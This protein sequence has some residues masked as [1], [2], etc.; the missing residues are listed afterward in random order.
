MVYRRHALPMFYVKVPTRTGW[1]SRSTGTADRATARQME[2][3]LVDLGPQ[4]KRTWDVIEAVLD[5]RLTLGELYDAW[6]LNDL[7]G[8][9]AR[10]ADEDL[11]A[12]IP[13]WRAWLTDRVKAATAERYVVHVRTLMPDGKP[14]LRSAFTG[15][16]V[17]RWLASRTKLV[18]KRK[19]GGKP[20]RKENPDA[21]LA[22]ASTKRRYFAAVQSF[23]AYLVEM[24]ILASNPIRD[25][26]PPPA[27]DP[28]CD[29]LELPDAKRLIE[30]SALPYRAIFAL[31]YGAGLEISAILTLVET[32]VD[33]ETRQVRAR[34]TK[35]WTRDRITRVADWAWAYVERYLDTLTPGE[36]VFRGLNRWD[37][38]SYHRERLQTLGLEGYRLH[39][40]RH[41]WAVRMAR[42][43]APFELIARQLGHRNVAMVAKVYGR[44]KP[45]TEERDRWEQLASKRDRERFGD[46]GALGGAAATTTAGDENEKS[47]A[48]H[49]DYEASDD[50]R[51]GT[52]TRDPGIMSAVL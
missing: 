16:T 23:T 12:H 28:R 44:F 13:G 33:R 22:S 5:N 27:S 50:S 39:D 34:G 19:P 45:D 32:D 40:A 43:G 42:A 41:H 47:P 52:R 37:A 7:E 31:A 11:T 35:A 1:V 51:G 8:L 9:R 4:G 15:P 24:G 2:R 6:R 38:S 49:S 30:G 46:R 3:M 18:Q 10:L 48:T 26:S 21:Q 14:Y 29:F 17:A 25:V 20:R 36:R